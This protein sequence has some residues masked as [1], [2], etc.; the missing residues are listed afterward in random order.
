MV[1][2]AVAVSNGSFDALKLLVNEPV[3]VESSEGT[4]SISPLIQRRTLFWPEFTLGNANWGF[5]ALHRSLDLCRHVAPMFSDDRDFLV[6]LGTFELIV[7]LLDAKLAGG[8]P[9]YPGYLLNPENQRVVAGFSTRI[10]GASDYVDSIA[11]ILNESAQ[12][13]KDQWTA[14]IAYMNSLSLGSQFFPTSYARLPA[15]FG[16]PAEIDW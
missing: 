16:G 11:A 1:A 12:E 14:R 9:L 8:R 3:E 5:K 4:L 2:G 13:F 6:S 15:T 10:V 7:G